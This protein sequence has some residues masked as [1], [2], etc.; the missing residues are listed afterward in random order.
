MNDKILNLIER[1]FFLSKELSRKYKENEY[2]IFEIKNKEN[3]INLQI[4]VWENTI[5]LYLG[6]ENIQIID[7]WFIKNEVDYKELESFLNTLFY[8]E[9]VEDLAYDKNNVLKSFSYNLYN[10]KEEK[11]LHGKRNW[12][13]IDTFTKL[14]HKN[15]NY[16]SLSTDKPK[17]KATKHFQP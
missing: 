16:K 12:S 17:K 13:L 3:I 8:S 14:Y 1:F 5:N 6:K 9:I 2:N 4:L 11:I 7:D 10:G 15:N